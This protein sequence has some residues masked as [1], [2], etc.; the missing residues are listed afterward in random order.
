MCAAPGSKTFQLLEM[1]HDMEGAAEGSTT[2]SGFVVANDADAQR[3]NLLTHQTKRM[4]SPC[5]MVT[6]HNG[7]Q[8]PRI[9]GLQPAPGSA[10]AA[11]A[12]AEGATDAADAAQQQQQAEGEVMRFDRILCDVPCSGDGTM[13]KAPDIWRRWSVNNGNGLHNMQLRIALHAVRLLKVRTCMC[14]Y[15]GVACKIPTAACM[16]ACVY[17]CLLEAVMAELL[18]L[19]MAP[20]HLCPASAL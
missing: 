13:R 20:F 9:T 4:C 11:A 1:L 18:V 3:C 2:P 16:H 7:E 5:L 12:A 14:M 17:A 10:A 15:G 19:G 8:F 6:N